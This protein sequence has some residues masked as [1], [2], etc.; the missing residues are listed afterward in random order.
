M[1]AVSTDKT[2]EWQPDAGIDMA[3]AFVAKYN[4]QEVAQKVAAYAEYNGDF[5]DSKNDPWGSLIE[6][7]SS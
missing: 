7:S 4:G 2:D 3:L 6:T 5:S 1:K